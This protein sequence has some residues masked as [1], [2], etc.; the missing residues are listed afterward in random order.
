MNSER[1]D[2]PGRSAD[3][4]T[5]SAESLGFAL[6]FIS[7]RGLL[8]AR[9]RRLG[10]IDVKLLE[11]EIPNIAFPFDV[12]GGADR[13]KA[14]RCFLRHLVLSLDGETIGRALVRATPA[15]VANGF[16]EMQAHLREGFV[17]LAGRFRFGEAQADFTLR[18]APILRSP[19]EL[20]VA[21]YDPRV[22]SFLPLPAALLAVYLGRALALPYVDATRA[23]MWVLRPAEQFLRT[24]LPQHGWKIPDASRVQLV[25]AD[26]ARG[27]VSI[28]AGPESDP[29]ER[30]MTEREPPAQAVLASEGVIALANA[31][32]ALAR[33]D[34]HEAYQ[35][36]R[37]AADEGRGGRWARERL[38]QIGATD[39][40]LAFDTRQLAEEAL[41][42]D[43]KDV[44]A[45]LA[46]AAMAL[47][48]RSFGEAANRYGAVAEI[49][50]AH[51]DKTDIV[52]AELA[53]AAAARP[54]DPAGALAAYERAAARARDSI[55]AHRALFE[56]RLVLGDWQGAVSAGE[57][58]LRLVTDPQAQAAVHRELGKAHRL[59]LR[60]FKQ[61]R[62]HFER[63]LRLAPDDPDALEGLAE[64]YAARGEPA[65]AASYL[66]R[67]AEQA[68]SSGDMARIAALNLRLGDIWERWLADPEAAAARYYRVLDADPK[69]RKARLRLARLAEGKGELVRARSLYEDVLVNEDGASTDPEA[70]AD[71]V[72]AYTRLARVTF[73]ATGPSAEAVASLERAHELDPHNRLARDELARFL[74][75]RREWSRLVQL[76]AETAAH[77]TSPAEARRVRLEA[78]Q[79]EL[80][81][82]QDT[83][84]AEPFLHAVLDVHPDDDEA[85]DLLVPLLAGRR[86]D[87]ELVRRLYAAAEA[88]RE[89]ERRAEQISSRIWILLGLWFLLVVSGTLTGTVIISELAKQ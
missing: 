89:P 88:T 69:N 53:A 82:R 1:H 2:P 34:V 25:T 55:P 38:L 11:L 30:Q 4:D 10:G 81:E 12:T 61:A 7:G 66:A 29:T 70:L 71:V 51:K 6:N 59:H 37:D 14:R 23:G 36:F 45:L 17:E 21:F 58:L 65:R 75:L 19:E 9:E 74:R 54:V 43:P 79:V 40:E 35:L 48:E 68:E 39:P 22:Y 26:V 15:L 49:A 80:F 67:L 63:A 5:A 13:F 83:Q 78:A 87:E 8:T 42:E 62:A 86:D 64:T 73:A 77:A 41:A 72:T 84:A 85:L 3:A 33:G 60:D 24:V 76:C 32:R 31:E 57:R 20:G 28:V 18:A 44:Q 16:T 50:H 27:R 46:L 56:L 52:A 47:R